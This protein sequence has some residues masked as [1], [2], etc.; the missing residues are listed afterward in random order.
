HRRRGRPDRRRRAARARPARGRARRGGRRVMSAHPPS[1]TVTWRPDASV[2]WAAATHLADVGGRRRALGWTV[3][4]DGSV[5]PWV[6]DLAGETREGCACR[7]CAPHEHGRL[8]SLPTE[9]LERLGLTCG[10]PTAQGRP[11]RQRV[12]ERGD[13]CGHHRN[14]ELDQEAADG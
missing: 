14:V 8:G 4:E 2:D 10:A 13:R 3:D 7:E 12:A 11:C 9:V 6:L 1:W 5:W